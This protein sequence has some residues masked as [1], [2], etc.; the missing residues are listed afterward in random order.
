MI[1][2]FSVSLPVYMDGIVKHI[3]KHP[4]SI[5]HFFPVIIPPPPPPPPVRNIGG[6]KLLHFLLQTVC[7]SVCVF[8]NFFLTKIS[9]QILDL[10]F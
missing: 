7:L 8:V 6:I 9:Q 5:T 1:S 4:F 2:L 10:G 3:N